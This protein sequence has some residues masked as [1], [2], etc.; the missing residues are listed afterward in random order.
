MATTLLHKRSSTSGDIPT[1]SSL[2]LGELAINTIDG[3]LFIKTDDGTTERIVRFRGDPSS[4]ASITHDTF[5]GD[6]STT[7]FTVSQVAEDEQFIFVTINGISQHT[8]A[9]SFSGTTLTLSEAPEVGDEI[10]VR[11][12]DLYSTAIKIRDYASYVYSITTNTTSISG[13]DDNG[14]TLA[15]DLGK[16]EVYY[17]GAKL[18]PG[19][20]FTA[21]D[22]TSITLQD[23]VTNGDTIEVISLSAASFV[24]N[25]VI[26]PFSTDASTTNQQYVDRFEKDDYRSAKYLVQMTNGSD[27]HVTEV[28]LMHDGTDT[29]ITEYGTMYTNNSL[30]TL[31][32]DINNNYVRLLVT[33]ANA[34]TT[35]VKGQRI[36]VTQ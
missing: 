8:D 14:D 34:S 26:K 7:Q 1:T 17:N 10:E 19:S 35:T 18:V 36:M 15:Y 16:V 11:I 12:V 27:Y 6:G 24:D 20:D 33:P 9:Y 5:S 2:A 30:G 4:E 31:S 29:Y 21:T 22:G 32:A 28:L 25:T 13:A 23:T 3:Y